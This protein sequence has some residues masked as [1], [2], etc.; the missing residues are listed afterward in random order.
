MAEL[1]EP[2]VASALET[3]HVSAIR[4]VLE[5]SPEP[6]TL[7]K[8]RAA[9]PAPLR[10]QGLEQLTDVL[11][12]QV[13]ANVLYQFPKYRSPQD[14]FWDRPMPVHLEYLLRSLLEERPLPWSEIRRKL[15][16]YAKTL[17]E[18]VLENQV[19]R[20]ILYRHPPINSRTGPRFGI[21]PP[22]PKEYLRSELSRVF[23]RLEQLGF[24][25]PQ[26]RAGA[27]E[28]LHEEEWS[29][30]RDMLAATPKTVEQ[31]SRPPEAVT[32]SPL[33]NT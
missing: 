12:R 6:L 9:L 31:E 1:I 7:S 26:I 29:P 4:R 19:A 15:P 14:R 33:T 18:P 22:D 16:D 8:I 24:T 2:T 13:A 20:G 3:D 21:R 23:E 30:S 27:I 5:A 28:L 32:P 17:A 25:V 10:S 11:T